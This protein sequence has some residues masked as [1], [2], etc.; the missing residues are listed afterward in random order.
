MSYIYKT[1]LVRATNISPYPNVHASSSFLPYVLLKATMCI[2]CA[3]TLSSRPFHPVLGLWRHNM[4]HV[5]WLPCHVP[6]SSSFQEN[7]IKKRKSKIRKNKRKE[8]KRKIVN[9]RMSITSCLS[10]FLLK[11]TM[12]YTYALMSSSRPFHYVLGLWHHIMWHV[13]WLPCH[14]PASLS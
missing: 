7:K 3:L 8:K 1:C 13:M 6:S 12:L 9:V 4:W 5:M 2:P 10:H 14:M 11:A